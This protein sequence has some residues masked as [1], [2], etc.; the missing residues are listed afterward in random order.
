[1]MAMAKMNMSVVVVVSACALSFM[2]VF[3]MIPPLM[4]EARPLYTSADAYISD[5]LKPH[6][7][8]LVGG[9]GQLNKGTFKGDFKGALSPLGGIPN[10]QMD[11]KPLSAGDAQSL[12]LNNVT[13]VDYKHGWNYYKVSVPQEAANK[14]MVV[15]VQ[16][17]VEE[18]HGNLDLF[19]KVGSVPDF[20]DFDYADTGCQQDYKTFAGIL[21]TGG[22]YHEAC[23]G[24]QGEYYLGLY[25]QV[26]I[27]GRAQIWPRII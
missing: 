14:H 21:V 25:S 23:T 27:K 5:V 2:S 15:Q 1:M 19:I 8:S 12:Q 3:H 6:H 11:G 4:C 7:E 13:Q 26:L 20:D 16:G 24:T 10:N 17:L 22:N 18:P 9:L